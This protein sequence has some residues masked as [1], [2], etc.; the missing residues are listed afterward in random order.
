MP[1]DLEG[2]AEFGRHNFNAGWYTPEQTDLY[3]RIGFSSKFVGG[4][5]QRLYPDDVELNELKTIMTDKWYAFD[6]FDK[7]AWEELTERGWQSLK[8]LFG[9]NAY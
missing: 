9:D 5:L 7:R 2:W 8:R 3:K 1:D 6:F 4:I